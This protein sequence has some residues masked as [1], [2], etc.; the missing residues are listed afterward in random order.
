[1]KDYAH[2][3]SGTAGL[4]ETASY[5]QVS[6]TGGSGT[7]PGFSPGVKY[8]GT[9]KIQRSGTNTIQTL[10]FVSEQAD[11]T[12][13]FSRT[14]SSAGGTYTFD[15]LAF[16][17]GSGGGF[18]S[19]KLDDVAVIFYSN[20]NK[21]SVRTEFTTYQ[22]AI[23][24]TLVKT[25][26]SAGLQFRDDPDHPDGKGW[27]DIAEDWGYDVSVW[28]AYWAIS[29]SHPVF[30]KNL[31][32]DTG[33]IAHFAHYADPGRTQ[34][35]FSYVPDGGV[36]RTSRDQVI[37][38]QGRLADIPMKRGFVIDHEHADDRSPALELQFIQEMAKIAHGKDLQL[39]ASGHPAYDATGEHSGWTAA[40]AAQI[41]A[42][43]DWYNILADGSLGEAELEAELNAQF[44][45]FKDGSGNV[46]NEKLCLQLSVGGPGQEMSLAKAQIARDFLIEKEIP[47]CIIVPLYATFGGALSRQPNQVIAKF[48]NLP[49]E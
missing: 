37:L 10:T 1:L 20:A 49:L 19:A 34:A 7:T 31:N 21:P 40:N 12:W 28:D 39:G 45:F 5:D 47:R 4:L 16:G 25:A 3:F 32:V 13:T 41:L 17:V 38:G 44:D 15:A 9:L 23:G 29:H 2:K 36:F 48:L 11:N 24:S 46:A 26:Y 33:D 18:A 22:K 43:L 27:G 6:V 8:V 30:S 14:D 42:E 35:E